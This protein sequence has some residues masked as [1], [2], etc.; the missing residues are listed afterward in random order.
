[1]IDDSIAS[2]QQPVAIIDLLQTYV[3]SRANRA[4]GH[5]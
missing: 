3:P 1:M 5:Y 2:I 4:Y